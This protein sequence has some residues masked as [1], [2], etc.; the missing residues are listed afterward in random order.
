MIDD[1]HSFIFKSNIRQ[2]P[3]AFSIYNIFCPTIM[4][5][6]TIIESHG[7]IEMPAFEHTFH[8]IDTT[9]QPTTQTVS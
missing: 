5:L 4:E 8:L 2:I 1:L 6:K 9:K 7:P 3:L